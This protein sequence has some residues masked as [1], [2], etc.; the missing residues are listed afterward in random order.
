MGQ[1]LPVIYLIKARKQVMVAELQ[2]I[3]AL[4]SRFPSLD[5]FNTPI[6]AVSCY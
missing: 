4:T 5:T 6:S 1:S 3:H 2:P